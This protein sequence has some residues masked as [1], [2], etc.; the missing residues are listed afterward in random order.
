MRSA[1][2]YRG[3][4][5]EDVAKRREIEYRAQH[6]SSDILTVAGID[7]T[8]LHGWSRLICNNFLN[9]GRK[10]LRSTGKVLDGPYP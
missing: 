10:L 3:E 7:K 2:H 8:I 1:L 4:R 5:N 9:R 6:I